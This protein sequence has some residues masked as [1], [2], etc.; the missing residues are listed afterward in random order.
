MYPVFGFLGAL[1]VFWL[2][3]LYPRLAYLILKIPNKIEE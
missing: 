1:G 2:K 3:N